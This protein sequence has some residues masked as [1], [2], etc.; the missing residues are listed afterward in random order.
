MKLLIDARFWRKETGGIG[1]YSR[2][3][4][5]EL[6][7]LKTDDEFHMLI[8][9]LDVDQFDITDKRVT[10]HVTTIGHYTIA[11]QLKL[12]GF[13]DTI[14]P[15]LVHYLNFNQPLFADRPRVTTMHDLT[16]KYFPAGRSQTNPL[17]QFAFNQVMRHAAHSDRVI[18]VSRATKIDVVRDLKP[19][20]EKVRVIYE[21]AD[22]RFKPRPKAELAAF[23]K[24]A[25]LRKPYILFVNQWR[26]HK[27]LP[28][29]I[30]AFD[31]L[32]GK[33][34]LPHQLVIT[35]KANP[36][37]PDIPASIEASKFRGEILLPGFVADEDLPRY[38]AAADVTAFPSFY[39]G[40]GLGVLESMQSGTPVV[41]TNTSS[42][43]EVA[44]DAGYYVEPKDVQA[45]AGGLKAVLGDQKLRAKFSKAGIEQAKQFSWA[46]M[47]KETYAVYEELLAGR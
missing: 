37:F 4:V 36:L 21:A 44:G 26:P 30:A 24:R 7:K 34:K 38:Y 13:I 9:E 28:E 2:E 29:L 20:P 16:M 33:Y 35:G 5:H 40:F 45:L 27:G 11:E 17:R 25:G 15:D 22:S 43:P 10:K 32:K 14:G 6:L 18:A 12:P 46:R 8:R 31:V 23:C 3:L 19:D 1:R 39:E 41:C 47:A 42:I